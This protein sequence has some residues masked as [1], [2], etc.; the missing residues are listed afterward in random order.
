MYQPTSQP[1]SMLGACSPSE[2][3]WSQDNRTVK[4]I[5]HIDEGPRFKVANLTIDGSKTFEELKLLSYTDMHI[6]DYYSASVAKADQERIRNFYGYQGRPVTLVQTVD[7][8]GDGLL[9]VDYQIE[10]GPPVRVISVQIPSSSVTRENVIR[11][12]VTLYPGGVL[13]YPD[14]IEAGKSPQVF[15]EFCKRPAELPAPFRTAGRGA[16]DARL[17]NGRR[18]PGDR[19]AVE[20]D[21]MQL[22]QI[23]GA[24][25][26]L[27]WLARPDVSWA[28]VD[29]SSFGWQFRSGQ[30]RRVNTPT[31]QCCAACRCSPAST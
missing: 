20:A 21:G 13:S 3:I 5:F 26:C 28:I 27:R 2:L 10:E 16:K 12:D 15:L 22:D 19:P 6:G 7:Q 23:G 25:I 29:R 17:D 11:R 24:S 4:L 9:N 31:G 30:P 8:A 18:I 1:A 14:L